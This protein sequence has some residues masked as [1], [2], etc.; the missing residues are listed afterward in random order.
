MPRAPLPPSISGDTSRPAQG[1]KKG[2]TPLAR[3]QKY[4]LPGIRER[5]RSKLVAMKEVH[6]RHKMDADRALDGG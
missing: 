4:D 6:R 1:S 5:M 3:P 2:E